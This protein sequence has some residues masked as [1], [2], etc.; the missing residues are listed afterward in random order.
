MIGD[1]G[2]GMTGGFILGYGPAERFYPAWP[3]PTVI[4]SDGAYG[5]GG[6]EGDPS[7]VSGLC[8]WYRPHVDAWSR[9]AMPRTSLW[10]WNTERGWAAVHPLLESDG[11]E[12]VQT[13]IW[14]KGMAHVAGNVNGRTI[15]RLPTVTEVSVLYRRPPTVPVT[16]VGDVPTNEWLRSEWGR[17]GLTMHDADVACGV[18]SMAS[19]RY[20][21]ADDAWTMPPG[22]MLERLAD[23]ARANGGDDGGRPFLSLD[24][25]ADPPDPDAWDRL[26]PVWNHRHGL[27]NVWERPPLSGAERVRVHGSG[28]AAHPDQKPLDLMDLQ[29]RLTSDPGDVVWEPFAGLAS[30][31]VA[32]LGSGR[33]PCAAEPDPLYHGL[34]SRR[35]EDAAGRGSCRDE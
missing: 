24:G 31:S 34:A 35:L 8:D 7:D 20:L 11:W 23:Y 1:G 29:I 18:R 10:F 13:V 33:F 19:R 22:S 32:A 27:T 12:Y 25:T 21:A 2:R 3:R 4:I 15:R 16:G 6:F 26:R 14:D 9:L 28:S 30:A 5:I 17:A